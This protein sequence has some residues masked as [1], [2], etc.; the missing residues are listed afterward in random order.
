MFVI[1]FFIAPVIAHL[2]A[3]CIAPAGVK[4]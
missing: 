3:R 1:S 2:I 4:S